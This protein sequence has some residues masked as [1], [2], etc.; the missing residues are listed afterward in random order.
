MICFD[1]HESFLH[2]SGSQLLPGE[3]IRVSLV[4]KACGSEAYAAASTSLTQALVMVLNSARLENRHASV[5]KSDI[6][7]SVCARIVAL[8]DSQC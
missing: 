4:C 3:M 5:S 7:Y 6:C 2:V 1:P 8:E